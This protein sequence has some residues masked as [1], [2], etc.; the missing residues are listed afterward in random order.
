M[1]RGAKAKKKQQGGGGLGDAL[2][3]GVAAVALVAGAGAAAKRQVETH[4]N[5][6]T[7]PADTAPASQRMPTALSLRPRSSTC[8]TWL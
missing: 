3:V 6:G 7:P 1:A 8:Q 2:G 4:R 5:G